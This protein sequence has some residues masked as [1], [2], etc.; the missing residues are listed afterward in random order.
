MGVLTMTDAERIRELS[1]VLRTLLAENFRG[2]TVA[3]RLQFSP[4]GRE[5]L[6]RADA[7]MLPEPAT[8]LT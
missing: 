2:H 1:D 7:A 3:E 5:L 6:H 4:A 8:S